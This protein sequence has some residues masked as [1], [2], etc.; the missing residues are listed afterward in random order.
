[1]A[2]SSSSSGSIGGMGGSGGSAGAASGGMGGSMPAPCQPIAGVTYG[3]LSTNGAVTTTPAPAVHGDINVKMRGWEPT[4]ATANFVDYGGATDLMAPRLNTIYQDNHVPSSFVQSHRVHE[5]NWANNTPGGP[6]QDWDVT[7]L[8][9]PATP[10]EVLEVP[11]SA[12]D[13]GEGKDVR[14]LYADED[15]LTLKYT[16]ED[17]VV[18]GYTVHMVGICVEPALKALYDNLHAAGRMELPALAG[19]QPVGR[20][21]TNSFLVVI[22]DTGAF[23]DPRSK[24][25]WWP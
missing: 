22:R 2:S 3:S 7:M 13:I 15:S 4:S 20:A 10:G 11:D 8:E 6:I 5:W 24:K 23:M 17:N 19:N 14:V 16:R 1:M 12:Y 9:F 18:S 21:K 25:D